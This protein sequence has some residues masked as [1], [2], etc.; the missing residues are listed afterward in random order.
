MVRQRS[1]SAALLISGLLLAGSTACSDPCFLSQ[2][3]APNCRAAQGSADATLTAIRG[4]EAYEA[5]S[6]AVMLSGAS[7]QSA[8]GLQATSQALAGQATVQAKIISAT[9]TAADVEATQAA[10]RA[11]GAESRS[12]VA[13]VGAPILE[14]LFIAA[15]A[16]GMVFIVWYSRRGLQSVSRALELRA[17]TLRYG[18]DNQELLIVRRLPNG[19]EQ[20]IN[21]AQLI[22]PY[23]TTDGQSVREV[24][25]ALNLPDQFKAYA[26]LEAMAAQTD[27]ANAHATGQHPAEIV[28]PPAAVAL[29]P[30]T[31]NYPYVVEVANGTQPPV[32]A[33]LQEAEQRL[34]A[35][36]PEV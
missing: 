23:I 16:A 1:I 6:N 5:T 18:P 21:L 20:V 36:P 34:L 9:L 35:A 10:I 17:A 29:P 26:Y 12:E 30:V 13:A 2:P 7:T 33:W 24:I 14:A 11:R 31:A 25:G 3:G 15:L 22:G 4:A 32:E 19:E 8:M 27:R 28:E